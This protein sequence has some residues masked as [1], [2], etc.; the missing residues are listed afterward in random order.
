[1]KLFCFFSEIKYYQS[2]KKIELVCQKPDKVLNIIST[3]IEGMSYALANKILRKKDVRVNDIKISDNIS[4]NFGEKIT[5]FAPD[6]FDEMTINDSKSFEIV[7]EDEK[8]IFLNK[9]KGIE[10][11]S[12]TENVTVENLLNKKMIK[13]KAYPLNRLDRNT[14]GLVIFAKGKKSLETLKKAM[15]AGEIEKYYL[16]E[17]IGSPKW[18][19]F[20]AVGYLSKDD[21]KSEVKIFD[22][23]RK[24]TTKIV[25]EISVLSRSS[26]GT[27]VFIVK[28]KNGKTHQIRAH[29][30]HIGFPI[31][32][33]GK[34]GKYEENKKFKSKTQKLTAYKLTFNFSD[35]EL[36]YLNQ[37]NIEITPS[38]M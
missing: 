6:N 14:E 19:N 28:I 5:V 31:I 22:S 32:G 26:G 13:A 27:C 11:C 34:Y 9:F 30:A 3:Q 10:V 33:D 21:E 24:D 25:T 17:V 23:S 35:S 12:P 18:E 7:Y 4:I 29:L 38:W 36:K 16:A 2:V 15:K 37:K 8:I 1:M 20:T